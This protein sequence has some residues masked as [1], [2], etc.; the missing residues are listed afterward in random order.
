MAKSPSERINDL[1]HHVTGQFP[2]F[3]H[4]LN[5]LQTQVEALGERL[6]SLELSASQRI[7]SVEE[8]TRQLE[9]LSDRGWQVWLALIAA[10]LALLVAFLKH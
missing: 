8:R 1:T 4:R 6:R 10:G 3:Q 5:E 9:K 7:A 2:V